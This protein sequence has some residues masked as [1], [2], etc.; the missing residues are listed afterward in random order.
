MQLWENHM[1]TLRDGRNDQT[2]EELKSNIISLMIQLC[3]DH[4]LNN[5]ACGEVWAEAGLLETDGNKI[6]SLNLCLLAY[7]EM[8]FPNTVIKQKCEK[9]VN[10]RP[11]P[12]LND[13][14]TYCTEGCGLLCE[15]TQQIF[16]DATSTAAATTSTTILPHTTITTTT[17]TTTT[18]AA[19]IHLHHQNYQQHHRHQKYLHHPHQRQRHRGHNQQG[20]ILLHQ[21]LRVY[22][23]QLNW[24]MVW[25]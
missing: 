5:D 6:L 19:I 14:A 17:T 21:P 25:I 7:N 2:F 20:I 3:T 9:F 23:L 10:K 18:T 15:S 11:P 4:S 13:D 1:K 22:L 12:V 16:D 24:I 8:L